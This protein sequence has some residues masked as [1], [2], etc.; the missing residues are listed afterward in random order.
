MSIYAYVCN[1]ETNKEKERKICNRAELVSTREMML[2][3]SNKK[4]MRSQEKQKNK[5]IY[6]CL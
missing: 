5:P 3:T 1:K 2:K 6:E 4:R